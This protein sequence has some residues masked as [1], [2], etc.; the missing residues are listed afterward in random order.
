MPL[1]S[2][3][4]A[5]PVSLVPSLTM[6]GVL[7]PTLSLLLGVA[8]VVRLLYLSG[9]RPALRPALVLATKIWWEISERLARFASRTRLLLAHFLPMPG[10]FALTL[11]LTAAFSALVPWRDTIESAA[12]A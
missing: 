12:L 5:V 10:Y 2:R 6:L 4:L 1:H 7:E 8:L 11:R 9:A 3:D